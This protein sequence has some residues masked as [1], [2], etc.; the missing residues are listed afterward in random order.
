MLEHSSD[1]LVLFFKYRSQEELL[2]AQKVLIEIALKTS[3]YLQEEDPLIN[4]LC[5]LTLT[6]LCRR[7]EFSL[8]FIGFSELNKRELQEGS[9]TPELKYKI[10]V[11]H[12]FVAYLNKM[13]ELALNSLN[14]KGGE[15]ER[16]FAEIFCALSYFRIPEFRREIIALITN[17]ND[18][19]ITEWRGI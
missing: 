14:L 16:T 9:I 4:D 13:L 2:K 17:G 11:G 15:P 5:W 12:M 10:E 19:D 3:E 18:P 7:G 6:A 8:E 1:S